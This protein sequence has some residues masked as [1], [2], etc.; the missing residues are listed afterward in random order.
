MKV[1]PIKILSILFLLINFE[2]FPQIFN[3]F[4]DFPWKSSKKNV[5]SLMIGLDSLKLNSDGDNFIVFENGRFGNYPVKYWCFHFFI[6]QLYEVIIVPDSILRNDTTTVSN[7]K[8][9]LFV[10]YNNHK[11]NKLYKYESPLFIFDQSLI[12]LIGIV[13]IDINPFSSYGD[14]VRI[15]FLYFPLAIE[16]D[17]MKNIQPAY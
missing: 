13:S 17:M 1:K 16:I 10:Q 4:S 2:T 11:G 12:N 15:D 3:D 14:R 7:L 5:K 6:D 9:D 8:K